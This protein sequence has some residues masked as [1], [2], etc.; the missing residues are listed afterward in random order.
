MKASLS[1]NTRL[2]DATETRFC[3]TDLVCIKPHH[4]NCEF[5]R[6]SFHPVNILR[7]EVAS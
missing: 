4:T 1:A 7:E 5:L 6:N 3:S 2:L